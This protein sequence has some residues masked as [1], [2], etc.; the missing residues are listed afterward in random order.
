MK[1]LVLGVVVVMLVAT[2]AFAGDRWVTYNT[3][4]G[5]LADDSV[6][7]IAIDVNGNK[8][9]GTDSGGVSNSPPATISGLPG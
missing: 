8:W 5:G 7:A 1:G 6:V 2:G 4:S 9:F 3:N